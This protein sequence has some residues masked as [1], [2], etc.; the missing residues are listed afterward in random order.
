MEQGRPLGSAGSWEL[1]PWDEQWPGLCLLSRSLWPQGTTL[2]TVGGPLGAP[3][4]GGQVMSSVW[5]RVLSAPPGEHPPPPVHHFVSSSGPGAISKMAA[6][7][8][9]GSY[10]GMTDAPSPQVTY[11]SLIS[12]SRLSGPLPLATSQWQKGRPEMLFTISCCPGLSLGQQSSSWEFIC[13]GSAS[14]RNHKSCES[15]TIFPAH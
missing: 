5:G 10:F 13:F 12:S 1:A 6:T 3:G 8:K 9:I 4:G 2:P 14:S 15:G 11:K 7:G